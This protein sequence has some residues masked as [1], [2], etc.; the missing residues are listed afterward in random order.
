MNRR[1]IHL[2]L[3]LALL[4]GSALPLLQAASGEQGFWTTSCRGEALFVPTSTQEAAEQTRCLICL[5]EH[6]DD[7]GLAGT[8]TALAIPLAAATR[9]P[10]PG[11]EPFAFTATAQYRIRAPPIRATAC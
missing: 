1:F 9:W 10:T 6:K 3:I 7:H 11:L 4:L 5:A 8:T 2:S